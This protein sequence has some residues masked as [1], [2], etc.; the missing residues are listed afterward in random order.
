MVDKIPVKFKY[1]GTTP[2][3][4]GEFTSEDTVS[5]SNGGTGVSSLSLWPS[6]SSTSV[7]AASFI[8]GTFT[9]TNVSST[10]LISPTIEFG[11][12]SG[13]AI[14]AATVS[15]TTLTSPAITGTSVS[16]TAVS[17]VTFNGM[18]YPPPF[19][20]AQCDDAG[21][22]STDEQNF[23]LGATIT[24]IV[25]DTDDITWDDTNKYFVVAKAGTYE[26]LANLVVDAGAQ[27]DI[28]TIKAKVDG[29]AGVTIL[30][31]LY[32]NVG[33]VERT[34]QCVLT[35]TAGQNVTISIEMGSTKTVHLETGSTFRIGR[36]K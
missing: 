2:S 26:L 22:D 32:G 11:S 28:L 3:A 1:G 27:N 16:A 21:T 4:L 20:Y 19:G 33:P 29:V 18:S 13:G 35:A 25:S 8:G 24:S 23:G 9:G 6:V 10:T 14:V 5:V 36:L 34:F 31:R 7:S 12:L 17:G 15:S 30:P